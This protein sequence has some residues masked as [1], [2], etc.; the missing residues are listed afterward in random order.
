[1]VRFNSRGD[2]IPLSSQCDL[3]YTSETFFL[4]SR[5]IHS[6][7]NLIWRYHRFPRYRISHTHFLWKW[8]FLEI[9]ISQIL[10]W[11]V[12]NCLIYV[13]TELS[14]PAMARK[15][16]RVLFLIIFLQNKNHGLSV[17]LAPG[18]NSIPTKN[19]PPLL[20][21]SDPNRGVF[22]YT[23]K[24]SACAGQRVPPLLFSSE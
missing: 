9:L 18:I 8:Y 23:P 13:I 10:K 24:F 15:S 11:Q 14:A 17:L 4:F 19:T 12:A 22:L 2:Q 7:R 3:N 1:M 6:H 5:K 21:I 16:H 20:R